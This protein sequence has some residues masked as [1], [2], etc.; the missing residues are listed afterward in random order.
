M[1]SPS[2]PKVQVRAEEYYRV[3]GDRANAESHWQKALDLGSDN[4][5]VL[6]KFA[7]AD[8]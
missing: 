2:S 6:S 7:G 3:I 4:I 5:L 8:F 1:L